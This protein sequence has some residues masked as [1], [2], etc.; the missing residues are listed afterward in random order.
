MAFASEISPTGVGDAPL[1]CG[2][3]LSGLVDKWN[4]THDASVKDEA[5]GNG[6]FLETA[7]AMCGGIQEDK[8]RLG[9]F[10]CGTGLGFSTVANTVAHRMYP[11]EHLP[12]LLNGQAQLSQQPDPQQDPHLFLLVIPIPVFGV[13]PGA[14]QSLLLI[15]PDVLFRDPGK[16]L[17]FID[18]HRRATLFLK[19]LYTFHKGE[20]Q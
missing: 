11:L 5:A 18:F 17:H 13:S 9:I 7:D 1:I 10:I 4:V 20:C 8:C 15:K 12:D 6:T 3:A 14:E 16:S 19:L 2:T